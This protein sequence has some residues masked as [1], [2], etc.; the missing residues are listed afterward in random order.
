LFDSFLQGFELLLR[1]EIYFYISLGLVVGM[2]VGAMPGL[3]T[4]LAMAV[5]LPVSFNLE[6]ML[7]IPFLIGVYKGGIYGGSISAILVGIPGTGASIATTF[8][9]PALTRQGKAR[10][11]LEMALFAST[12]ADFM[13]DIVTL[14]LIALIAMIILMIGPPEV[15]AII[16]FSL[17]LIASVS[18]ESGIR[19][20]IA[21]FLG[22]GLG[23]I[24]TDAVTGATRMTFGI[25]ALSA[26][27][28]LIPLI[29]GVFALP[30]ILEAVES[31][32]RSFISENVDI[33][34]AGERLHWHEFKRSIRTILRSTAIG[35]GIGMVPGV[36][37]VVAAFIGYSAA[38]RA[39]KH[40]ERFGKGELDG[41]AGPEA[42]NNAVNGPTLV[43]LLT[44]G[45]PG[46]N[47]TAILLGAF[48]A[49]GI[50]P[51]PQIFVEQG[52]LI[53]A[54]LLAIIIANVLFIFLGY[55]LLKPFARAIQLKKAYLI[56]IILALSFVGTL[57]TGVA[58]D[59]A[60]MVVIGVC[61]Y[62]LRK[63]KFDLAPLV[64]AFVL[65]EPIEYRLSQSM[66]YARGDIFGYLF[67]Q[68]PIAAVFLTAGMVWI[69]WMIFG[70]WIRRR[71]R[72][73]GA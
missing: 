57:S 8:D 23:F 66:L 59:L 54:L 49:H 24:G 47:V 45:I 35:T 1:W 61:A 70:P 58:S 2:F 20:A 19:G 73:Q 18:G 36:G 65:A 29:I 38:K 71:F 26:G 39:S 51:G 27:I 25:D 63:L 53:Y 67:I 17:I 46:D 12:T 6:P 44:L 22:L 32:T 13:S 5:L 9:G 64:I 50:R 21:A 10:K 41:V 69:A 30:E 11:A 15:F 56:P 62:I 68:R 72:R 37:Q 31:R 16:I 33:S 3:T 7:G 40:P 42:A 28:P 48:V 34:K 52:P 43:P 4:V 14:F 60:I 55:V